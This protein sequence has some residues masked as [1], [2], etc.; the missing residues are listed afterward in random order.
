MQ[1][2][3]RRPGDNHISGFR[4][5]SPTTFCHHR[6][7]PEF[8]FS[9]RENQGSLILG[10]AALSINLPSQTQPDFRKCYKHQL[11]F[12]DFGLL[13]DWNPSGTC[14]CNAARGTR[15]CAYF[16]NA[17]A[18]CTFLLI[19]PKGGYPGRRP[20]IICEMGG[21][22][23]RLPVRSQVGPR[24]AQGGPKMAPRW[25]KMAP[26]WGKMAPRSPQ[27]SPKWPKTAPTWK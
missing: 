23:R 8:A 13:A 14:I 24:S 22:R 19:P 18:I 20:G 6:L 10:E 25:A 4:M 2:S 5:L 12:N 11:I 26:R 27:D 16:P 7:Q 9:P 17:R 1:K 15:K 3:H 21:C